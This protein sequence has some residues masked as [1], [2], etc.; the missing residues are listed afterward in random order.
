MNNCHKYGA[1]NHLFSHKCN[2]YNPIRTWVHGNKFQ[3]NKNI[4]MK[5]HKYAACSVWNDITPPKFLKNRTLN[6]SM[7][8]SELITKVQK[9]ER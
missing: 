3:E 2:V 1:A 7:I 5:M 9:F 6:Q 4:V 8:P